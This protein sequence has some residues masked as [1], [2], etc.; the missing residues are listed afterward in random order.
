[1]DGFRRE[2]RVPAERNA[3]YWAVRASRRDPGAGSLLSMRHHIDGI[4]KNISS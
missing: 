4:K 1:M 3:L 2:L